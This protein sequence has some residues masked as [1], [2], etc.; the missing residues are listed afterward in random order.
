MKMLLSCFALALAAVLTTSTGAKADY[1][2]HPY[3]SIW[4]GYGRASVY[5]TGDVPVP[6]Y[7]ALHPPV[8][9][10][11]PVPRTYGYSPFAYPEY[12][13][14][15]AYKSAPVKQDIRNP[16]VPESVEPAAAQQKTAS[17]VQVILNPYVESNRPVAMR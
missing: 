2:F 12:V 16:H 13:K 3:T 8:Y 7:F 14:T 15:P 1:P 4:Y 10:S 17:A 5:A 11:Y 9:Y 6:P